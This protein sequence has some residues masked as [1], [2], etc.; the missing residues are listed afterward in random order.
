[1]LSDDK[2]AIEVQYKLTY[3]NCLAWELK[4]KALCLHMQ[5]NERL[6][7]EIMSPSFTN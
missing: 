2:V 7:W 4:I 3:K 5:N 1:M 6:A